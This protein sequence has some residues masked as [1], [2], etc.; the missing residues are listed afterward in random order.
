MRARD[1][2]V[3]RVYALPTDP[4]PWY[5]S[6][7]PARVMS[8]AP[9]ER[10][11]V[12]LPDGAPASPVREELPRAS[13]VWIAAHALVTTWE[14]WPEHLAAARA[15]MSAVVSRSVAALAGAGAPVLAGSE[16]APADRWW[17]RPIGL[18]LRP[19][20]RPARGPSS[21]RPDP[22]L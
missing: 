6:A 14:Q 20:A 8:R 16:P 21:R 19:P 5:R 15:E 3:G 7:V 4:G 9:G 10:V 12:L 1:V 2:R 17:S 11:L 22:P 13:L 18:L